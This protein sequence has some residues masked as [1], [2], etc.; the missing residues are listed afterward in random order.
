MATTVLGKTTS[1]AESERLSAES[2]AARAKYVAT[3]E[4]IIAEIKNDPKFVNTT[5]TYSSAKMNEL[6]RREPE[7]DQYWVLAGELSDQAYA[8]RTPGKV[9]IVPGPT[10]TVHAD[11]TAQPG[12]VINQSTG[13]PELHDS[14]V[15]GSSEDTQDNLFEVTESGPGSA[16]TEPPIPDDLENFTLDD[17]GNIIPLGDAE[18][19]VGVNDVEG[20]IS[21]QGNFQ[22]GITAADAT[23][24]I[25]AIPDG[26]W[27]VRLSLAPDNR[28]LYQNP[29]DELA[30][31]LYPLKATHGIIFPYTPTIAFQHVA[32][33]E[34]YELTH[35]NHRGYFYKG[36]AV[37][38]IMVPATFT[39][40]DTAEATYMLAALHFLRSATKMF[41]GQDAE[42]GMPPPLVFLHGYGEYGFN[43]HPCVISLMNYNLPN[44]VDYIP[45]GVPD[46]ESPEA[47]FFES[48]APYTGHQS[49]SSKISRML[50]AQLTPGAE[51]GQTTRE[52][53][54]NPNTN[55]I[56]ALTK[57]YKGKT[58]VPT[59]ID[60]NF[61][62]VPIQTRQQVSKE[63]SLKDYASGKLLKGGFW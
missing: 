39:A 56:K 47:G 53:Q 58:Y 61:N 48:K 49:W 51:R 27:R 13:L 26:D 46:N 24:V 10:K 32:N 25:P 34:N 8:A 31:I 29:D 4:R 17:N 14:P 28:R 43:N 60:I 62:M 44:D 57:I 59:K 45:A 23:P 20:E 40:Q 12:D 54:S 41:Y 30:G 52:A 9:T 15:T 7:Y 21:A 2:E 36:S 55:E 19:A 35:S 63:F 16:V 38:D 22:A 42:R 37:R 3:R 11:F 6:K 1:N 18:Q 33:Y 5:G 50:G